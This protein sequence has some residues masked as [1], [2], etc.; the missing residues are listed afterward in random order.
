MTDNLAVFIGH[1]RDDAVAG[2]S[3][4]FYKF[5]LSQLTEG[6]RNDLVNSLPVAWAFIADDNHPLI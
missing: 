6:R 1:Q 3:Q 4:F 5:S 2:F